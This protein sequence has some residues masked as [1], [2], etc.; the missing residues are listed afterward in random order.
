MSR[1]GRSFFREREREAE[2]CG[3]LIGAVQNKRSLKHLINSKE[4]NAVFL[5]NF[6]ELRPATNQANLLYDKKVKKHRFLRLL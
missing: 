3:L 2:R 6:R 5:D 1:Y 4:K